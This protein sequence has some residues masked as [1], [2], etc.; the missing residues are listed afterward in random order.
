MAASMM[1]N[2]RPSAKVSVLLPT[3]NRA[4]Y[5]GAAINSLLSQ[6]HKPFEI[7]ILD[8]GST[9]ETA[10][11]CSSFGDRVNYVRI[12]DNGGKSAAINLGIGLARGDFIWIMDDDDFVLPVA[13]SLLLAPLLADDS[14]GFSFGALRKFS[15]S[16]DGRIHFAEADARP[17]GPSSLFVHLMEDCFITGQPCTLFRRS[18][19]ESLAP[20]DTSVLS[21]VDYNI[22]LQ[23]ARVH[24]GIDV[25]KVVLWQRQHSG[26]RGP[27]AMRYAATTR[28]ERWREFDQRLIAR[29]MDQME[30]HEYL[31][32][33][34][35]S[36]PLTP[37]QQRSALVQKAVI[38]G[39]KELWTV[40]IDTLREAVGVDPGRPF[41]PRD[42]ETLARILGS[43]YGIE[44]L[45]RELAVQ[46]GLADAATGGL[47]SQEVRIAIASLLTFW[48]REAIR[49]GDASGGLGCIRAMMRI[50]G[51]RGTLILLARVVTRRVGVV[52]LARSAAG[53]L[54][55]PDY[56]PE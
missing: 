16:E 48:T 15:M 29:L 21:S 36:E 1:P 43:R 52:G 34:E 47:N 35:L 17:P 27:V 8:D 41:E 40:A 30:L 22:L 53:A 12:T 10:A 28:V 31:G 7:I 46:T 55:G 4:R 25:G 2:D 33:A 23:V 38:A 54:G 49:K 42:L 9:D 45:L 37:R 44:A 6:I 13:L 26:D 5:V 39:R 11:I 24:R 3:F 32:F 18:C 50:A 51:L 20:F 14:L 56:A 19:L